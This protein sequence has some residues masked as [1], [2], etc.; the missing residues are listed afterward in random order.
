MCRTRKATIASYL[1]LFEIVKAVVDGRQQQ[2]RQD[3]GY[4]VAESFANGL[5]TKHACAYT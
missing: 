3:V 2:A 5:N 4:D 1:Y